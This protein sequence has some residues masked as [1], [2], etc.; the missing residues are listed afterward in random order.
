MKIVKTLTHKGQKYQII[1]KTYNRGVYD[2][3]TLYS[4]IKNKKPLSRAEYITAQ[5]A[6]SSI[7][8]KSLKKKWGQVTWA[9]I[10]P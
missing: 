6:I 1:S 10:K 5:G 9:Q 2:D 7:K 3:I 8:K 4:V